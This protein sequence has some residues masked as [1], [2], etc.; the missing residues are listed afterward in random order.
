[1]SLSEEQSVD[2]FLQLLRD[3]SQPQWC[4]DILLAEPTSRFAIFRHFKME[5]DTPALQ[6]VETM[7]ASKVAQKSIL[8]YALQMLGKTRKDLREQHTAPYSA[9]LVFG[10]PDSTDIDVLYLVH[11]VESHVDML[12]LAADMGALNA[13]LERQGYDTSVRDVDVVIAAVSDRGDII[14]TSKGTCEQLQ[15]IVFYT[16]HYHNNDAAVRRLVRR[17]IAAS[18]ISIESMIGAAVKCWLDNLEHLVSDRQLYRDKLR[19]ERRALYDQADMGKRIDFCLRSIALLATEET[20]QRSATARAHW[21]DARKSLFMKLLQVAL[22]SNADQT[23]YNKCFL[24]HRVARLFPKLSADHL[25]YELSRGCAGSPCTET[26]SVTGDE[27]GTVGANWHLLL[28]AE[29]LKKAHNKV[30]LQNDISMWEHTEIDVNERNYLAAHGYSDRFW[31]LFCAT[32]CN[33]S[34]ELI[35]A[36]VLHHAEA[37]AV[38][39]TGCDGHISLN[40]LFAPATDK[41]SFIKEENSFL[42]EEQRERIHWQAQRTGD[43]LT[44]LEF[45]SC[46]RGTGV[47]PFRGDCADHGAFLRHHWNL[48]RGCL[49]EMICVAFMEDHLGEFGLAP[50]QVEQV[51][52]VVEEKCRIGARGASPDALIVSPNGEQVFSVEIKCLTGTFANNRDMRRASSLARKQAVRCSRILATANKPATERERYL[53][54]GISV[55]MY[56][57]DADCGASATP[58]SFS[59]HHR[60]ESW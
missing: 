35:E 47:V 51:G 5:R 20:L 57:N 48:I 19:S 26:S 12:S 30:S 56:M 52:M 32:P 37:L 1:M 34:D 24:T 17:S 3:P 29:Q 2:R 43:W 16:Q 50:C 9:H 40:R 53:F 39:R 6:V 27:E 11:D 31:R 13:H 8:K 59:L 60:I 36:F 21:Q 28:L 58:H 54:R 14:A 42:L 25:D 23:E 38:N 33:P 49:G 45:Y 46:G 18:E 55:L 41:E 44:L 22:L 7:F 15:N 4:A 10:S